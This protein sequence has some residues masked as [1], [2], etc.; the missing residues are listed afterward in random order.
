MSLCI[1]E[2]QG[3]HFVC[4]HDDVAPAIEFEN[5]T[6]LN[7]LMAQCDPNDSMK[8]PV[9]HIKDSHFEWLQ[10]VPSHSTVYY[11]P[12]SINEYFPEK[13]DGEIAIILVCMNGT[14]DHFVKFRLNR[15]IELF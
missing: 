7:L 13:S 12:P 10:N 14:V 2:H 6:E 8:S 11:T 3:Q 15:K 9:E 5:R 4:I 1:I